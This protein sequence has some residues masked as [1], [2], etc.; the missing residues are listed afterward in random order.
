MKRRDLIKLVGGAAAWP[1][2]AR[3]Q[4]GP[5]RRVGALFSGREDDPL[6]KL[7]VAAFEQALQARGWV[8][9]RNVQFDYR[10]AAADDALVEAYAA[11]LA[12]TAPDAILAISVPVTRAL[13][14]ATSSVPIVFS[15]GGDPVRGG[16]VASLARPG[17]TSPAFSR[18]S[19]RSR[20]SGLI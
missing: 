5:M 1:M 12:G 18:T 10:W 4:G 11:E 17:G 20:A 9:G 13:K 7:Q 3:A 16:I 15:S 6:V 2:A 19:L 8:K 14:Q